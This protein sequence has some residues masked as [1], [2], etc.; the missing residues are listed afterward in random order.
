MSKSPSVTSASS[1]DSPPQAVPLPEWLQF[2]SLSRKKGQKRATTSPKQKS[3]SLK[4][5]AEGR[6]DLVDV[7]V[8]LTSRTRSLKG[9]LRK[10][11]S[12]KK[13]DGESS[14]DDDSDSSVHSLKRAETM[15][16]LNKTAPRKQLYLHTYYL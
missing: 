8:V 3:S 4:Q 10:K 5:T 12:S 6:L 2:H 13:Y 1:S 7:A 14:E 16:G 9:L 15:T 11:K